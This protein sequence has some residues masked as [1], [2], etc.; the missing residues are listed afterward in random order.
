LRIAHGRAYDEILQ[1][2][3][4]KFSADHEAFQTSLDVS[5]PAGSATAYVSF[6][7]GTKNYT[8]NFDISSL[9]LQRLRYVHS[10]NLLLYGYLSA[11]ASGSGTLD[12]PQL[13]A[14]VQLPKLTLRD[15]SI[16][17]VKADL[18]VANKQADFNLNSLVLDASV[19]AHGKVN[20][21]GGYYTEASLDTAALPLDV[22]L[23]LY[24][25]NLPE[26]VKG[27]TEFHARLAGH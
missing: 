5:I 26:G 23:A 24:I 17:G 14:T 2:F 11:S 20:L 15:K 1:N 4:M 21:E 25:P 3:A 19:Q 6:A 9:S 7:P 16:F 18:K 22:L 27:Q 12:N 10:K 8:M 13:T